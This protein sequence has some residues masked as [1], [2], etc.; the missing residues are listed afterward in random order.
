MMDGHYDHSWNRGSVT[1]KL[2]AGEFWSYKFISTLLA[3]GIAFMLFFFFSFYYYSAI[4]S[5]ISWF[6]VDTP[7]LG[8]PLHCFIGRLIVN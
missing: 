3:D 2:M 8:C 4:L 7:T 6:V 1:A 5:S